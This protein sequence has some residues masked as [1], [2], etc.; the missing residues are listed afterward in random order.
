V[1][2]VERAV[3]QGLVSGLATRRDL[4]R[5]LARPGAPR[6]RALLAGQSGPTLTRSEAEERFLALVRAARLP[7]PRV[8]ARAYGYEL[9]FHW[10]DARVVVE[11][12]GY[13]FHSTRRAFEGD[14]R[15][16]PTC[17]PLG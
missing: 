9:D 8:N 7:A 11:I 16:D 17:A 4:E 12:D 6:L 2:E 14:H 1:R 10:P 13:A 5:E 15:K 3:D